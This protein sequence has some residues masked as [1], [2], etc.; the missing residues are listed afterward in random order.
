[1]APKICFTNCF[2]WIKKIIYFLE[3]YRNVVSTMFIIYFLEDYR[4]VVS[5]MF[6]GKL[7]SAI[8]ILKAGTIPCIAV[9]G[10]N[11]GHEVGP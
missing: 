8:K 9:A 6:I 10:T 4:N 3:D 7:V 11:A 2:I 5:T 1:V